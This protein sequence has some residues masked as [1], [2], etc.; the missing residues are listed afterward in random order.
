[1]MCASRSNICRGRI[2]QWLITP[3]GS[4]RDVTHWLLRGQTAKVSELLTRNHFHGHQLSSYAIVQHTTIV[5]DLGWD[6]VDQRN[7]ADECAFHVELEYGQLSHDK[8]RAIFKTTV[9]A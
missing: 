8:E 5:F 1:M 2:L 7:L 3:W 9:P 4:L 6:Y